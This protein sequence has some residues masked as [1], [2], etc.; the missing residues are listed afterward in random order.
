MQIAPGVD[1]K[2]WH[3]LNLD[4]PN[5]PDW[6][7]AVE[8]L[9][10]RILER[11]IEPIDYLIAAEEPKPAI[12]RRFGFAV[13]AIDCLLV[14][15]LGAFIDGLEDTEGKS[16]ATF[17]KFLTT[18]PLFSADF[19]E[20]LAKQFYEEFRCGILHQAEIGGES[21]V[22][23][24]GPL[25]RVVGGRIIV[26]RNKFHEQLKTEFQNYLAELRDPKNVDLR[27]NFRKKMDFISRA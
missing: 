11:F 8:I 16:K 5:N 18:R 13:L 26:N 23:S 14:E 15:T 9:A 20:D 24:V 3:A 7:I 10:G 2:E 22:W 25:V 21:K 27:K 19:T 4:D 17:C 1:A 12:E 6:T